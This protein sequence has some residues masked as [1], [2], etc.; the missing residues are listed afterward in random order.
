ML[1]RVATGRGRSQCCHAQ[2]IQPIL[3]ESPIGVEGE[4]DSGPHWLMASAWA[5]APFGMTCSAGSPELGK[6]QD[7]DCSAGSQANNGPSSWY[8]RSIQAQ[9]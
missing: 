5:L 7:S 3:P 2:Q 4:S 1:G 6:P 8:S 9:P